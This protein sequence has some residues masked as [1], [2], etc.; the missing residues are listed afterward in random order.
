MIQDR[1][2]DE[3]NRHAHSC[4]QRVSEP[5]VPDH[6]WTIL[7]RLPGEASSAN[8]LVCNSCDAPVVSQEPKP[9][10]TD[11]TGEDEDDSYIVGGH[12]QQLGELCRALSYLAT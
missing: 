12:N 9:P 3:R 6:S 11:D 1:D 7:L 10:S 8:Q 4:T 2:A 5:H